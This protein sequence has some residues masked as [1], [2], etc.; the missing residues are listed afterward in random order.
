MFR[1]GL[2]LALV[3]SPRMVSVIRRF[4]EEIAERLGA[5]DDLSSR[6][7]LT[8]H[9]LLENVAKYGVGAQGVLTLETRAEGEGRRL[10]LTVTN[11]TMAGHIDRLRQT[12]RAMDGA[13]DAFAYYFHLMNSSAVDEPGG[14]GLARIPAEADMRLALSLVGDEVTISAASGVFTPSPEATR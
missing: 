14:L 5:D 1:N 13:E 7:A 10:I 4:V 11:K 6:V 3:I 9:E 12:F 2:E 8:A